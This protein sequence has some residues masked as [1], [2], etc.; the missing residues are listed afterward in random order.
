MTFLS[1][2]V[3]LRRVLKTETFEKLLERNFLTT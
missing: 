2:L 3:M 1:L